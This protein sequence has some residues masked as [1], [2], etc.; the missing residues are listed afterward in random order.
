MI[1]LYIIILLLISLIETKEHDTL[2]Q[3]RYNIEPAYFYIAASVISG[4]LN[5]RA[6]NI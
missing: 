4:K 6:N 5:S 1:V 2:L 3:C